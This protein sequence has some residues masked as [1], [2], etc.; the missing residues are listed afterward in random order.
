MYLYY[1]LFTFIIVQRLIELWVA[2]R[3]EKWMKQ[4]GGIEVGDGHY[5]WIVLVHA[6]FFISILAE[7]YGTALELSLWKGLLFGIF[8]VTQGFRIW[9]LTS[10]GRYWNTKIIVLPGSQLVAKGPYRFMKH[11]NYFVVGV[12]FI[13]IPLLFDA[14]ISA[15]L[16]PLFHLALMRIRIPKEEEAL[17]KAYKS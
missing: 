15:V 6:L 2:K 7:S 4:N 14:Y 17:A 3:N 5:K 10:L 8:F 12:E 11:P 13:I 9:C 1:V 16:F